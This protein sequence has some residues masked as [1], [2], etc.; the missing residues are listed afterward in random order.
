MCRYYVEAIVTAV[1]SEIRRFAGGVDNHKQHAAWL[2]VFKCLVEELE[3]CLR[4][5]VLCGSGA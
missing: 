2:D 4:G 5:G 3:L 1:F